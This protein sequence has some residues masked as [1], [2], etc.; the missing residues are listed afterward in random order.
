[1]MMSVEA[2]DEKVMIEAL[3]NG[4][5]GERVAARHLMYVMVMC[6]KRPEI[7]DLLLSCSMS[8]RKEGVV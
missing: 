6:M 1:M 8:C 3:Y 7:V 4:Q 2:V 5:I